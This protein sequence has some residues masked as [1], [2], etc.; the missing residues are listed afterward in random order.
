MDPKTLLVFSKGQFFLWKIV[1]LI[2]AIVVYVLCA[3]WKGFVNFLFIHSMDCLALLIYEFKRPS[4]AGTLGAGD[5][6]PNELAMRAEL[7]KPILPGN[8]MNIVALLVNRQ[9][10]ARANNNLISLLFVLGT[11][12]D[13][14]DYLVVHYLVLLALQ[15]KLLVQIYLAPDPLLDILLSLLNQ[16]VLNPKVGLY[17]VKQI[18]AGDLAI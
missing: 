8:G 7:A 18:A 14:A 9:I 10:A 15:L 1:G 12:A 13:H 3:L 16:L 11:A 6:L 5:E 17:I 4:I 2:V